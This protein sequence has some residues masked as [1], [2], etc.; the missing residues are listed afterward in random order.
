M[1]KLVPI[2]KDWLNYF[3]ELKKITLSLKLLHKESKDDNA[4]ERCQKQ[5][6]CYIY[7]NE[8]MSGARNN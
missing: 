5:N 7:L 8:G 1:L 6:N 2:S 3:Y 4:V